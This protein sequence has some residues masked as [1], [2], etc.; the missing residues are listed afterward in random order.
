[1][2]EAPEVDTDKLREAIDE[3][4]EK[5][6]G[7]LLRTIALTTAVF[8]ALAAIAS[9]KAGGSANEALALKTEATRL[10]AEASDKWSYYQAKNLKATV[11][12]LSRNTWIALDKSAPAE[13]DATLAKYAEDQRKASDEAKALERERDAKSIEAD[14]LMHGHHFFAQSVALLQVAI[15]LGA[16][17]A[18]T[19]KRIVWIGSVLLGLVGGG[20]FTWAFAV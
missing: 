17:A 2:P 18:L 8:A 13:L 5:E 9:L 4:I 19:R 12:E 20:F 14:H 3:E 7:T 11:T 15:A 16:V 6:G 1:M 10:Q